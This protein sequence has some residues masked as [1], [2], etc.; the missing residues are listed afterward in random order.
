[1]TKT[2]DGFHQ[3]HDFLVCV[4]SDG[5]AFDVM[6]LKHKECF[7]PA[8]V[9][10]W[11]LQA[12]SR[13]AREVWDFV[14]L[15]SVYRGINR[16]IALE[17]VLE[18]LEQ[19][20]QIKELTSFTMP[21]HTQLKEWIESGEPLNNQSL[22]RHQDVPELKKTL[23]WSLDCNR[24]IKEM[25]RGVPPFPFVRESLEKMSLQADI[26][27]VSA[28]STDALLREWKEHQ[29]LPYA[30]AVC[31]QEA[32]SKAECISRVR[33]NYASDCCL[34][35]GDAPG[36][37]A[38]ASNNGILFYP[39]LPLQESDSWKQFYQQYLTAFFDG[40]YAGAVENTLLEKFDNVLPRKAPWD[41]SSPR[42]L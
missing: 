39:I 11:N 37:R 22:E 4:D 18:L 9:N 29:L 36:D 1:M 14:N 7:C 25:V 34:M 31:G 12:V 17:T 26:V 5:C 3:N 8:A 10:F 20:S 38:A 42:S 28:T 30:A 13:Y 32:G 6:E 23:E 19:R 35:I 16:F 2:I 21:Q 15:Y 24:R 41:L 33:K 27:I 40:T